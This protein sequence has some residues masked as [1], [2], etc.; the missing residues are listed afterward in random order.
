M[1]FEI[2]GL[3]LVKV[4]N[5]NFWFVNIRIHKNK[6][7]LLLKALTQNILIIKPIDL[8]QLFRICIL[9]IKFKKNPEKK[10]TKLKKKLQTIE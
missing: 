1:L 3:D 7:K 4:N 5:K 10:Q 6:L 9:E 8:L 2:Y